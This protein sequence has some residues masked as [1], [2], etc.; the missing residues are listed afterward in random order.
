MNE[1]NQM[2]V[3]TSSY[4]D[5]T[6][7]VHHVDSLK[8]LHSTYINEGEVT[9]IKQN[10]TCSI[11][12]TGH[13]DATIRIWAP[14]KTA[15]RLSSVKYFY[16]SNSPIDSPGMDIP[17]HSNSVSTTTSVSPGPGLPSA[18]ANVASS[19]ASSS[20]P[21]RCIHILC[22]HEKAAITSIDYNDSLDLVLSGDETGLICAHT[23][24]NGK[25]VHTIDKMMG[26]SVDAVCISPSG[27]FLA[28][29]WQNLELNLF[30]VN[31][32]HL[33]PHNWR[34]HRETGSNMPQRKK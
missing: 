7:K 10:S 16:D 14:E 28:H 23:V 29:S 11:L 3:T 30:W 34:Q 21:L 25:L 13:D 27:Y 18:M 19:I 32:Q 22:G 8:E 15:G 33:P 6:I 5:Y 4:W 20:Q 17:F 9:V 26:A 1:Q 12:I 24:C 2:Q 31:G